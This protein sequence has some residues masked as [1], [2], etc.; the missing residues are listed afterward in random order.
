MPDFIISEFRGLNTKKE[1]AENGIA[2]SAKVAV[3][4]DLRGRILK[5][6]KTDAPIE[7]GHVG[8]VVQYGPDV[9]SGKENY[10]TFSL[11]G[12]DVLLYKEQGKWKRIVR[13][14]GLLKS[15]TMVPVSLSQPTPGKASI[16]AL[17]NDNTKVTAEQAP[18]GWFY[19]MGYVVTFVR[20]VDGY[21]DESAPSIMQTAQS[22]FLGFRVRRPS[23]IGE[24]VISWVIYRLSTGYRSTEAFQ[25]VAEV[26]I[27]SDY[28]DDYA[29]GNELSGSLPGMF[30]DNGV[31]ILRQPA[32]VE[33]DGISKKLYYGQVV[34]WKD[35]VIY[36]SEP[37]QPESYP[38][39]YQ[40][41]CLDKIVSVETINGDLYAFTYS[42]IQRIVGSNPINASI[43][44]DYI[45]YRA[46]G[47]RATIST[48]A[49]LYY[50]FRTGIGRIDGSGHSVISR[51]LLSDTYFKSINMDSVHLGFGNGVLYI[52]HDKGTLLYTEEQG[53]GFTEISNVYQGSFYDRRNGTVVATRKQWAW[54]LHSGDESITFQY[55]M[56]GLVLNQPEDKRF[57]SIRF[58]GT[59]KFKVEVYLDGIA[60]KSRIIDLGGML[61]DRTINFPHGQLARE[62][63]WMISGRGEITEI[64]AVLE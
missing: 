6:F 13:K 63:S 59:G 50:V 46:S 64:K 32:P 62:A 56:G 18:S 27:G 2:L 14:P 51:Y 9:L 8:E 60:G 53:I 35:D 57:S 21:R 33:F 49:G 20:E 16:Q 52:F 1:D 7:Q 5:A 15:Q 23:V 41:P 24:G 29:T 40:L 61:R 26:S 37:N 17:P 31:T 22:N 4:V 12:F 55:R 44:P 3:N 34:G 11:N 28:F 30:S 43:L 42:G 45:G 48:E 36:V 58:F 25:K 10:V 39:Q 47:S 19:E 54:R 38:S